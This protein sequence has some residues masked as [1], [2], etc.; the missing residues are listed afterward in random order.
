[1]TS[2]IL[3]GLITAFT[4]IFTAVSTGLV[5]SV[6]QEPALPPLLAFEPDY[7]ADEDTP[8]TVNILQRFDD[9]AFSLQQV[10]DLYSKETPYAPRIIIRTVGAGSDYNT[11]LRAALLSGGVDLFQLSGAREIVEFKENIQP[12]RLSWGD[13]AFAGTLDAAVIDGEVMALPY[14]VEGFGFICNI[15]IFR[16]AGIELAPGGE[17]RT[18]E[19]LA[20]KFSELSR[21]ILNG[22]LKEDFPDLEAVCEFPA[23]D[24]GFL[25][26]GFLDIL[27]SGAFEAPYD[28]VELGNNPEHMEYLFP[29]AAGSEEIVKLMARHSSNSK[30]WVQLVEMTDERQVERLST[31]K[32]A[33]IL[34]GT[35]VYRQINVI[36]PDMRGRLLLLPAPLGLYEQPSVY[37]GAPAY[38]AVN[39]ACDAATANSARSFL[40]WLYRSEN[41]AAAFAETL[42]VLSPYRDTAQSTNAVLHNQLVNYIDV[43]MFLPRHG[44]ELSAEWRESVFVPAV[45]GYFT[46]KQKTWEQVLEEAGIS[47]APAE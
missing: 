17:L 1:M 31:G 14:S 36:N 42:G 10:S 43:G 15:G 13:T 26:G 37:V 45:Q 25:G 29:A 35:D 11:A 16:A 12:P 47:E 7:R 9:A 8:A 38:W 44:R 39:A 5:L 23:G 40:T 27:L 6:P 33:V 4:I 32:V 28:A 46:D 34:A 21:A 3:R 20:E 24:V 41:G 30:E 18:S 22:E 2:F 19:L